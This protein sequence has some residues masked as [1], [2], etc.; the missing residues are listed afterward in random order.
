MKTICFQVSE[1]FFTQVK[2]ELVSNG[3]TLKG[4]VIDLITADLERQPQVET[5]GDKLDKIISLLGSI[6][7]IQ[8]VD[9]SE[10]EAMTFGH[11]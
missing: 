6:H 8:A 11:M 1:E 5:V 10:E 3:K 9:N 2:R 7:D 4:Y